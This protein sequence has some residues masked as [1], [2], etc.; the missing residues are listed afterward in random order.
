MSFWI[1]VALLSAISLFLLAAP[2]WRKNE[3]DGERADYELNVFKDQLKELDKDLER[4]LI[5][6]HEAKTARV[7]IQRRLLTADEKRTNNVASARKVGPKTIILSTLIGTGLIVGSLMLYLE[8]GMPGYQDVPF[9]SRNLEQERHMAQ[10]PEGMTAEI[11][12]LKKHLQTNP[13][14]VQGWMLLGRTLRMV[15]RVAEAVDAYRGAV[16]ASDRHPAV[17]ADFAESKIYASEG[18]VDDETFKALEEAVKNDPTQLKA[19]FYLGFAKMRT[20]D[21]AG[22]VQDWTDLSAMAPEGIDWMAQVQEQIKIAAQAGNLN[23]DDFKPS[24]QARVLAKQFALQ[25]EQEQEQASQQAEQTGGPSR[26]DMEA[27]ADMTPEEREEMI[28]AMVARLADRLK[29]NPDDI[30]GWKR[31]A[32]VYMVLGEKDKAIEARNKVKELSGS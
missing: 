1:A 24:A 29:E 27:A 13:N 31:L 5:N 25:W 12:Q 20:K 26:A 9:A 21:Y 23:V 7:E 32:K 28:R 22:A 2:L 14:D 30:D 10:N 11:D 18:Q 8:L 6:A 19:R 3:E 4:G 15:G 16:E 17:L